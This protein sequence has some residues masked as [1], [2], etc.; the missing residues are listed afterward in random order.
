MGY[1]GTW[2][3]G[4]VVLVDV[5][6]ER[7]DDDVPLFLFPFFWFLYL[8]FRF[9]IRHQC[10]GAGKS[11]VQLADTHRDRAQDFS[12]LKRS[13]RRASDRRSD[14]HRGLATE[15]YFPNVPFSN[16]QLPLFLNLFGLS[17]LETALASPSHAPHP[18]P[19]SKR[20][21]TEC[22]ATISC[23]DINM[24]SALRATG[25]QSLTLH[26]RCMR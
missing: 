19:L 8:V 15:F 25:S 12:R 21:Q 22:E 16:L 24:I 14:K 17:I 3:V 1:G 9:A 2:S 4:R 5:G 10:I 7:R 20:R 18:P 23:S 11:I 13:R 6:W 26:S